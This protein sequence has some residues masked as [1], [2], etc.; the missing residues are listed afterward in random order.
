MRSESAVNPKD[1]NMVNIA[2]LA[3]RFQVRT[4]QTVHDPRPSTQTICCQT[5]LRGSCFSRRGSI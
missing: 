1:R 4:A 3:C 2:T 5:I